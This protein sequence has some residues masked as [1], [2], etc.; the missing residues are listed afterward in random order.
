MLLSI[1]TPIEAMNAKREQFGLERLAELVKAKA[2][3]PIERICN[4]IH[5]SVL[6][7]CNQAAD[8]DVTLLVARYRG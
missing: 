5:D 3:L 7:W 4:E 6:S 2:N 8:D 1:G